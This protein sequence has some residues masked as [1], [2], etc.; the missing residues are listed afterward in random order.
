M[1]E[2]F[3]FKVKRV[4]LAVGITVVLSPIWLVFFQIGSFYQYQDQYAGDVLRDNPV[5]AR[6]SLEKLGYFYGWNK[7]LSKFWLDGQANKYLF[8]NA[9]YYQSAFD[10]LIGNH[11]KVDQDLDNDNSFWALFLKGN[12]KWRIAQEM[13]KHALEK[14]DKAELKK[15]AKEADELAQSAKNEY[16]EAIKHDPGQTLPPK[17]NYD[18]VTDEDAR[19]AG[20]L[21]KPPSIK[22]ILGGGER[23][24]PGG[25]GNKGEPWEGRSEDIDKK[26]GLPQPKKGG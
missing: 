21:P 25:G 24:P 16:E 17:W 15:M 19:L 9:P 14:K 26:E 3:K 10:Y 7:T 18:L 12:V 6:E 2:R 11:T 22:Q 5:A 4:L 23:K 1:S 13:Y 20:L 8:Y